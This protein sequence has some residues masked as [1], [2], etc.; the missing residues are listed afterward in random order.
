MASLAQQLMPVQSAT[1]TALAEANAKK[2]EVEEVVVESETAS[3]AAARSRQPGKSAQI[4]DAARKAASNELRVAAA[5]GNLVGTKQAL[6]GDAAVDSVGRNGRTPLWIAASAGHESVVIALLA[7]GA[8]VEAACQQTKFTPLHAAAENGH[9]MV[10]KALLE[11]GASLEARNKK[12]NTPRWLAQRKKRTN[13]V[14]FLDQ[15]TRNQL[16]QL[17]LLALQQE[18]YSTMQAA[19]STP[20]NAQ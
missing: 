4:S 20:T 1:A 9:I 3:V 12:G 11:H 5:S 19:P 16:G 15:H 18:N 10:A 13:M 2:M 7:A 6:A 14:V 8:N 17:S